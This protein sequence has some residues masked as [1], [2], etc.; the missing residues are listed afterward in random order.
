MSSKTFIKQ[1][2]S[3]YAEA[4]LNLAQESNTLV[5]V[6]ED[7]NLIY[8]V[9]SESE[10]L[11]IFLNNPLINIR[12]KKETLQQ[13]FSGQISD[14]VLVFL[15]VLIDKKR[16]GYL[17]SILERYLELFNSLESLVIVKVISS[18]ELT[19]LQQSNLIKQLKN[20]TGNNQ[21][22]L[23]LSINSDLIAGFTIQIGSKV[24]DTSLSGQLKEIGYFLGSGAK[25]YN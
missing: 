23:E 13:L 10:G 4:L 9:L 24:I 22:Q 5:R 14:S 2:S 11:K 12:S 18:I 20:M 16:I 8:Q 15:L 21:I 19:D 7:V 3:P 6:N 1:L 25:Y 17:L